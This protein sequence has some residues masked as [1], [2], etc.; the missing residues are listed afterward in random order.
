MLLSAGFS[1]PA[2]TMVPFLLPCITTFP[3]AIS[4][5]L[6][7]LVRVSMVTDP[8]CITAQAQFRFCLSPPALS[9]VSLSDYSCE[10][11]AYATTVLGLGLEYHGILE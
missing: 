9:T 10:T 11:H 6:L 5:I 3:V 8:D 2:E 1:G 7:I 4:I